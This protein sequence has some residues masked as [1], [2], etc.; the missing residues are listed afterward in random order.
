MNHHSEIE[1]KNGRTAQ[2]SPQDYPALSAITWTRVVIHKRQY[3]QAMVNGKTTYMHQLV[4]PGAAE[5]DHIN[6]DGLDNRRENLRECTHGQ[7][8]AHA[9]FP[10]PKS[11]YRG[12]TRHTKGKRAKP[13]QARIKV[14]GRTISLGYFATAEEAAEAYNQGSRKFFGEFGFQNPL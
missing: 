4:L 13:Y 14:R 5:V 2:C 9:E 11:G 1:M 10:P 7:N 3:A 6:R 8:I 12:V